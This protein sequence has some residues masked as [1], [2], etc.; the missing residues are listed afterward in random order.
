[1]LMLTPSR[2]IN[3][4]KSNDNICYVCYTATGLPG[5][6]PRGKSL[7]SLNRHFECGEEPAD[8]FK[9]KTLGEVCFSI[10]ARK[11]VP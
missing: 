2:N 7:K 1:M 4:K 10:Y 11:I 3:K 6:S 8:E 5:N 9:K